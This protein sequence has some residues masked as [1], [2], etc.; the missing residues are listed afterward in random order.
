MTAEVNSAAAACPVQHHKPKESSKPKDSKGDDVSQAC[1]FGAEMMRV[2]SHAGGWSVDA[3]RF[4]PRL[5]TSRV[6]SSIPKSAVTDAP[7]HQRGSSEE[8]WEYPSEDMYYKAMKRKGWDP[9]ATQMQT[10]VAI[11]NSV[12]EQS[13]QEVLKWESFHP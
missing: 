6:V 7:A 8:K 10:I 13:W 1:G 12:N 11:H 9:D 2:A 3:S 5:S 4:D